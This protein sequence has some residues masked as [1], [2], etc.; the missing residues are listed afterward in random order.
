MP[1]VAAGDEKLNPDD[2]LR[3]K[4]EPTVRSR[5]LSAAYGYATAPS[6]PG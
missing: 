5:Q 4:S 2:Q 6:G 3:I 1:V